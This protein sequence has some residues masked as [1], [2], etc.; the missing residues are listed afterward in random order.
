MGRIDVTLLA[1]VAC[2]AVGCRP[3]CLDNDGCRP[4]CLDNDA[5]HRVFDAAWKNDV[6]AMRELLERDASLSTSQ[7]RE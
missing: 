7:A 4:S 2:I 6:G 5:V 3:S 1:I